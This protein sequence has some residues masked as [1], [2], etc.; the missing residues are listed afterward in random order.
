[1]ASIE[2]KITLLRREYASRALHKADLSEDPFKQFQAWFD[3]A[4]HSDLAEP[5]AMTLSTAG[6]DGTVSSRTVLLKDVDDGGFIF[7]TNYASRKGRDLEEN[8]Q[9]ALLFFWV[10]LQRQ[11]MVQGRVEKTSRECSD[12]YFHRRP[13]E[14]QV[15][16]WA[17]SQSCTIPDRAHLEA[18]YTA[19]DKQYREQ[20]VPLPECWGG[21]RVIPNRVEFWQGRPNRLHDRIVF[22]REGDAWIKERLSP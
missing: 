21:Y 3:E 2:E 15:G 18:R 8:P 4:L 12:A 20:Q 1:M 14:A 5:N 11:V 13:F 6:A 10:E 19:L 9:A 22:R 16:A 7:F 17:S